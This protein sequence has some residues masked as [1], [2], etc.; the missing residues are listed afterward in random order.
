MAD[1]QENRIQVIFRVD[2]E[3]GTYQDALWFTQAEYDTITQAEIDVMKQERADNW[4]LAVTTPAPETSDAEKLVQV[5][6]E[7]DFHTVRLA[8][9]R[10]QK[11]LTE[12]K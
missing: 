8:E 1:T 2:T 9:L 12:V 11:T 7:I 5:Q 6:S 3:H 4:I 10:E